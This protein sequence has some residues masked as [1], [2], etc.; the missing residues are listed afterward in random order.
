MTTRKIKSTKMRLNDYKT[1]L[2]FYKIDTTLMT[3]NQI[4]EKAEHLLAVK[5]CKCIKNIA[6]PKRTTKSSSSSNE[7]RA[8][9]I[10][11]NSV[12]KKKKIKIFNFNCKKTAKILNKKGTRKVFIE[13]LIN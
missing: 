12:I 13:K 5:L 2:K 10:C 3:N 7:K 11:Y 6:G 8:I 4:K 1:I 9:S